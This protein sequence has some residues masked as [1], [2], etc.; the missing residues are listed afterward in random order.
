ML[1]RPH[2]GGVFVVFVGRCR[3]RPADSVVSIVAAGFCQGN[4]RKMFFF[5]NDS[6]QSGVFR[7][8]T[9]FYLNRVL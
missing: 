1:A 6:E 2:D 4:M 3:H 7:I 5:T 9:A 8:D